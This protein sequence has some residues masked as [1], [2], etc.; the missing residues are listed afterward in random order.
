MKAFTSEAQKLSLKLTDYKKGLITKV[1]IV[2]TASYL[3]VF[4][5][6]KIN[7]SG[8]EKIEDI[9]FLQSRL[10]NYEFKWGSTFKKKNP[11]FHNW[12]YESKT[13]VVS[14]KWFFDLVERFI[15]EN[16][17]Q[18]DLQSPFDEYQ[19]EEF[20]HEC[21]VMITS[22]GI[23]GDVDLLGKGNNYLG[24]NKLTNDIEYA[25]ADELKESDYEFLFE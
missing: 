10:S 19:F 2:C 8:L 17:L 9:N 16:G 22:E 15:D 14:S 7:N 18:E 5:L 12:F 4:Q 25:V 6:K 23:F 20:L 3:G 21:D 11:F 1:S 24:H 13:Q